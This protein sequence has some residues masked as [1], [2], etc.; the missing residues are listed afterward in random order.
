MAIT[1]TDS[2]IKTITRRQLN[3]VI[4]NAAYAQTQ[5][6]FVDQ[7]AKLL[8]VDG[9]NTLFYDLYDIQAD[10]YEAEARY[11]NGTIAATYSNGTIEPYVA[12]ALSSSAKLEPDSLFFPGNPIFTYFGMVPRYVNNLQGYGF[13]TGVAPRY[14]LNIMSNATVYNGLTEMIFR[15]DNGIAGAGGGAVTGTV[16]AGLTQSTLLGSANLNLVP[17]QLI[18]VLGGAT[19]SIH[20]VDS[21]SFTALPAPAS[22]LVMTAIVPSAISFAATSVDASVAAFTSGQRE[23][24]V[25]APY[26][27]LLNTIADQILALVNEWRANLVLQQTAINSLNDSRVIQSVQNATALFSVEL[28]IDTID[29]WLALPNTGVTGRYVAANISTISSLI[30]NR[31]LDI[32]NR[33]PQIVTALGSISVVGETF[34]GSGSYYNRYKWL[35]I[36]INRVYGSARRYYAAQASSDVINMLATANIAIK[37]EYDQFFN[38]KRVELQDE[39]T[40]VHLEDV[41]G[42]TV[43]D[44]ITFLSET[45]PPTDRA[46]IEILDSKQVRIDKPLPANYVVSLEEILRC[47]KLLV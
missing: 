36:R 18:Y 30:T 29:T 23:T 25:A 40:I 5:A 42:Y 35:D 24:L 43:T 14:E 17:G 33:I 38:T 31:N 7:M 1:F 45:Q 10:S 21:Y 11:M 37:D 39:T 12:G 44:K 20:I 3:A 4:E 26:T 41:T 28:A 22:V 32:P 46:I 9:A 47:Y 27:Y 2:E 34:S 19:S 8:A 15:L 6:S 16:N 13:P